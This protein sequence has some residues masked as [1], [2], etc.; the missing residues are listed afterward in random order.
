[1]NVIFIKNE[2]NLGRTRTRA[3][4]AEKAK[5]NTLLFLDADVMPK[6]KNFIADY[7]PYIDSGTLVFG[8]YSYTDEFDIKHVLRYKYG[9]SREEKNAS[10]RSIHPYSSIFSGN[11]LCTK[12]IFI[13]N[14]PTGNGY[15][16]DV[17]F[18]YNLYKNNV[19]VKHIDNPILHLGL[20][21]NETFF[22][23]CKE[24][25]MLRKKLLENADGSENINSLLRHYKTLKKYKLRGLAR[26]M[27][28][29][30]E[31][32]LKRRILKKDPNLFCLDIYRLGYICSIK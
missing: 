8:G 9:K 20:E 2:I 14:N 6:N 24:A 4:L 16:M 15:G 31:P 21:D 10:I 28:A 13:N 26:L 30:S 25:V 12:E 3:I 22:R 32:F 19:T 17:I 5:Y 11:I 27:F 18:C 23:K 7:M 1:A 29:L